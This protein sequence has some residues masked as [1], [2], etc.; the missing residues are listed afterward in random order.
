[1]PETHEI[2][3]VA[4]FLCEHVLTEKTNL[5]SAIR[6]ADDFEVTVPF[7]SNTQFIAVVETNLVAVIKAEAESSFAVQITGRNPDGAIFSSRGYKI[8]VAGGTDGH[9]V[10]T[11]YTL[12]GMMSGLYWFHVSVDGH[13]KAKVPLRIKHK[14]RTP[15]EPPSPSQ[16]GQA[17]E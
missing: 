2:V 5:L 14:L 7:Q 10:V 13:L 3:N 9:T 16:G 8:A 1:M 17:S 12:N 6:M 15:S 11:S 4:A